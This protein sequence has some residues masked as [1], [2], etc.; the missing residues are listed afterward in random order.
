MSAAVKAH[1]GE[2]RRRIPLGAAR[3]AHALARAG[4]DPRP[5]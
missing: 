2:L 5:G 4:V 3:L 1:L